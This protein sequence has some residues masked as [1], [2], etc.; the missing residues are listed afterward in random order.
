MTNAAIKKKT[1]K[2]TNKEQISAL[3]IFVG[4]RYD[5]EPFD[6]VLLNGQI[7]LL[8]KTIMHSKVN[9]LFS[10]DSSVYTPDDGDNWMMAKLNVQVTDL[11]YAQIVEHLAKV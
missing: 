2:Q 10:S 5:R 3:I 11:G 6:S 9:I 4:F 7:L 8:S 1:N